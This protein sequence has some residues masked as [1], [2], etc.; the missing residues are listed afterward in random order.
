M[1]YSVGTG[2][3]LCALAALKE[4]GKFILAKDLANSQGLPAPYLAKLLQGLV[5]AGLLDSHRGPGGGFRLA[6]PADQITVGEVV[7]ILNDLD[8]AS[9]CVMGFSDC[10][11]RD[12]ACPLH[13]A[14]NDAKVNLDEH[15]AQVTIQAFHSSN[16][17][18]LIAA[19]RVTPGSTGSRCSVR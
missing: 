4:D 1:L 9:A 16:L 12:Q 5:R 10:I 18:N 6:R 13:A 14:W 17:P 3:A 8:G 15:M 2:Y 19:S 7:G 11:H